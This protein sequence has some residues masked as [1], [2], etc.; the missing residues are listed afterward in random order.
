MATTSLYA[1]GPA[2]IEIGKFGADLKKAKEL[3][4][5]MCTKHKLEPEK[6]TEREGQITIDFPFVQEC[7]DLLH[8]VARV[9]DQHGD[10]PDRYI[11]VEK[12]VPEGE[13][14]KT[15]AYND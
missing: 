8:A 5:A 7:A 12:T 10:A 11:L 2:T 6:I 3:F 15:G 9:I 13:Y 1:V 14:V 4:L